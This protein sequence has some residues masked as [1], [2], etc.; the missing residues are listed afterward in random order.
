MPTAIVTITFPTR[1]VCGHKISARTVRTGPFTPEQA[2]READ[3]WAISD[4]AAF[5][6]IGVP[7]DDAPIAWERVN[8]APAWVAETRS[9]ERAGSKRGVRAS[10]GDAA[11]AKRQAAAERAERAES[12][13]ANTRATRAVAAE[14][15]VVVHP[16]WDAD[17]ERLARFRTA[18]LAAL[19]G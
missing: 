2:R 18:A 4:P 9:A 1:V 10:R 6:L 7:H 15:G 16:A 11:A 17:D 3:A 19:A 13:A 12:A 8:D 5:V 14:A